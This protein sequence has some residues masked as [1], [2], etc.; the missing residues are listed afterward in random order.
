MIA[1]EFHEQLKLGAIDQLADIQATHVVND[2][3]G[4]K[5]S[6]E[7][8]QLG[9]IHRFKVDNDMPAKFFDAAGELD[10]LLPRC[11]VNKTLDEVEAYTTHASVMHFPKLGI[12][13]AALDRSY[14]AGLALGVH[15]RI[16]HRAVVGTVAGGLDYYVAGKTKVVS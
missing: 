15:E 7:V 6:E 12:T 11:E 4:G 10:Q 1:H 13:D 9:Q 3:L 16:N 5:G 2:N 8:P 14:A